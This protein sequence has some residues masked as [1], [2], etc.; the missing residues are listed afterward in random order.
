MLLGNVT[1]LQVNFVM[2][3]EKKGHI[4]QQLALWKV[5]SRDLVARATKMTGSS[6]DDWIYQHLG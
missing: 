2:R 5:L 3:K 6:S 1:D 4:S